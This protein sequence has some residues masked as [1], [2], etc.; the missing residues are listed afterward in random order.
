MRTRIV[1]AV[2]TFV[3]FLML[4]ASDAAWARIPQMLA[5]W[6]LPVE[7]QAGYFVSVNATAS[8][9]LP[10]EFAAGGACR[11]SFNGIQ[12]DAW[13]HSLGTCILVA[14]QPGNETYEPVTVSATIEVTWDLRF[15]HP[16]VWWVGM[17]LTARLRFFEE[18]AARDVACAID[19]KDGSPI[20]AGRFESA[21][22]E[23]ACVFTHAYDAA[24]VYNLNAALAD[25]QFGN[26]LQS[27]EMV[28]LDRATLAV[29]GS[30]MFHS[31][32]ET[33]RREP[34][35]AGNILFHIDLRYGGGTA[36]TGTIWFA[37]EG[38]DAWF[39]G[40]A[41][42]AMTVVDKHNATLSGSGRDHEG[43]ALSYFVE[44]GD[45]R[46]TGVD[47]ISLLLRDDAGIVYATR[48][49]NGTG[50]GAFPPPFPPPAPLRW[51]DIVL[52][53]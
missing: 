26:A 15:T 29:T 41:H 1:A 37:L 51:G 24:G 53:Y 44:I 14:V 16:A 32:R 12:I 45:L 36:P 17:P 31:P 9:G 30:G 43:R 20:E 23:R 47:T 38:T 7:G 42:S 3:S 13:L 52:T 10:V 2:R 18:A 39:R 4:F 27:G 40:E 22:S 19:W 25:P 8:S 28:V 35:L 21:G 49:W 5:F 34:Q 46:G 6:P 50:T 48:F 33:F 11:L